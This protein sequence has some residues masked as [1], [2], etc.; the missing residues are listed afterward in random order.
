MNQNRKDQ[1]DEY[2]LHLNDIQ[3]SKTTKARRNHLIEKFKV[4][5]ARAN[6]LAKR[7]LR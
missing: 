1:N 7:S 4:T 5:K 6:D 2:V 3:V